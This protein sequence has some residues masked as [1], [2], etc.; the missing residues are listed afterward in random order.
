MATLYIFGDESGTMP[1][2]DTDKPFVAATVAVL[3]NPPALI[4]GSDDDEKMV[5]IFTSLNIVPFAAI[6]NLTSW[7]LGLAGQFWAGAKIF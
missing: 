6:V 5:E 2:S 4:R 1:V 7:F 3:D